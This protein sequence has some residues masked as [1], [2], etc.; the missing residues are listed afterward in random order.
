MKE[1]LT[2]YL[3]T[4]IPSYLAARPSNNLVAAGKQEVT[5]Q[6]WERRKGKYSLFVSE[7]VFEEAG[8]GDSNA[9]EKRLAL[10]DP[11]ESL[12]VDEEVF[13]ILRVIMASG[14]IPE[15]AAPDATHIAIA[16]RY[17][18]DF[19]LTWN[20]THIANAEI[21]AQIDHYVSEAGYDLPVI[22]TP[23]ELFGEENLNE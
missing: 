22:C 10:I 14:L 15:K 8:Q 3:E 17:A 16:T 2:V 13:R 5:R 9:A 19:L 20:C 23:D 18:L 11:I 1:K 6:W 12:Q 4:T 21:L 7:L